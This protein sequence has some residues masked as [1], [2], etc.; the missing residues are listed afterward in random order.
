MDLKTGE[1]KILIATDVAS[2]GIDIVDIT[3]VFN[4]DFPRNIEEYVHRVGRTGRAG[5]TG[6]A[7]SL[8]ERRGGDWKHARELIDI[9]IEANQEVP[10]PLI[11]MASRY[12]NF[13]ERREN[14]RASMRGGGGG[15]DSGFGGGGAC[16]NRGT[17]GHSWRE[18]PQ[19]RGGRSSR[20]DGRAK[21]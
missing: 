14:E 17:P 9:L 3:Y 1:V 19:K 18:C 4:F 21:W 16:F 12:D 20:G 13:K 15:F 5:R 2:R 6:T 8:M 11:D 10:Q 7:I